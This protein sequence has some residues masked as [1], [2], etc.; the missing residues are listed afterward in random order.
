MPLNPPIAEELML[1][2]EHHPDLTPTQKAIVR[3]AAAYLVEDTLALSDDSLTF[4]PDPRLV[5]DFEEFELLP[6]RIELW[7]GMPI[8]KHWETPNRLAAAKRENI[9][10]EET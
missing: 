6:D 8:P 9:K 5:M 1:L 3:S 4:N 10:S 2:L 7:K